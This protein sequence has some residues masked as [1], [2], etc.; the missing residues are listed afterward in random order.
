MGSGSE[1]RLSEEELSR[2]RH[3]PGV[4]PRISIVGIG[5]AGNKLLGSVIDAGGA[6]AGQCIAI[7]TDR[8][9]LARSLAQNKVLLGEDIASGRGAMGSV[10]LGRRAIQLSAHRV[11]SFVEES[12]MTIILV[13]FGGGTGTSAA[14]LVAQ[15]A[16]TQ[17]KPVVAVVALPFTHEREKRFIAL[18]GLKKM[19]E[20]CDCTIVVDNAVSPQTESDEGK[21]RFADTTAVGTV[22]SISDALSNLEPGVSK[23]VL[24]VMM[25]GSL[26]VACVRRLRPRE[27]ISTAL[28]ESVR[29]PSSNLP[30]SNA[31]GAVLLH[32]GPVQLG[33]GQAAQ[34]HE[35]ISSLAGHKLSF[36]YGSVASSS[37]P[38]LCTLLTGYDYRSSIVGFVELLTDL[39]DLEYGEP[40]TQLQYPIEIP[41]YQL[42]RP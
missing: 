24:R 4:G 11:T 14:P 20:A 27:N 17:I 30:L 22:R 8:V 25:Q 10:S 7:N 12:D 19:S 1:T 29:T 40:S 42:E 2:S 23:N 33:P 5:G 9:Q 34:M 37:D 18:R 13:G 3:D 28:I 32:A 41:L 26:A 35:M 36:A 6:V 31:Q 21:E 39:Y 16:R 38:I 15:W